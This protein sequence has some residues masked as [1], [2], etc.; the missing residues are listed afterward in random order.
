MNDFPKLVIGNLEAD[1]PIIQGGMGVGISGINLASAVANEGGIGVLSAAGM[2]FGI[3]G[4]NRDPIN[5]SIEVLKQ[6]IQECRKRSNGIIGINIMVATSNFAELAQAAIEEHVD[7]I[8]AGAGL[9]LDL[10]QYL[11]GI[12]HTK[13]V[14]VISSAK[15]ASILIRRWKSRFDYLP[16]AF[17][18][19]GPLAG[20]HL[21][22]K[23]DQIN[24]PEYTLEKL[25]PEVIETVRQFEIEYKKKIPVI[26]AGGVY[27]GEDIR[28]IFI[29]GAA[30]VQMGTRF[31]TTVECDASA[32]FKETYLKCCEEDLIII[33]SPV[34]L[35]GRAIK[36][37]FLE[38]V[39][40][41]QIHPIDCPYQCIRTCNIKSSP[42][43]IAHALLN[44]KNG[45]M[46]KGFAFAG[47]NAFHAN[48][49]IPVHD[50]IETLKAEFA[51]SQL[52]QDV[53]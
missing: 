49:I 51:D 53:L 36:N 6:E 45:S 50:L 4:Y 24:N 44:A 34:G 9:P 18:L 23:P 29:Y 12:N 8:F 42:Y 19:E 11:C 28:K 27:T 46:G 32:E 1:L 30:G 31:V 22:F 37:K 15:A 3:P 16:D 13:L 47:Q 40:A 33:N 35:P 25:I 14:P 20:G 10:P 26:A 39:Q 21:R 43:C 38:E 48:R 41:G 5:I 2:G 52:Y 17:V 7:I